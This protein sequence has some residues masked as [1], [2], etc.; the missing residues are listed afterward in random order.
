M[1]LPDTGA[2]IAILEPT[3]DLSPQQNLASGLLAYTRATRSPVLMWCKVLPAL[4]VYVQQRPGKCLRISA[5]THEYMPTRTASIEVDVSAS[6]PNYAPE[7]SLHANLCTDIHVWYYYQV[8]P[9]ALAVVHLYGPGTLSC[10]ACAMRS[11]ISAYCLQP[12]Y[13]MPGADVLYLGTKVCMGR[14]GP[15]TSVLVHCGP[16]SA[17]W[18]G[19][20]R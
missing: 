8:P 5:Y 17:L 6:K 18:A 10:Y 12:Q 1:M 14:K 16:P 20:R 15:Y 4:G 19:R 7:L 2:Y 11:P 9:R 13:K 3:D